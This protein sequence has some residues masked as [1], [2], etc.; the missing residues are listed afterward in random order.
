MQNRSRRFVLPYEPDYT[1]HRNDKRARRVTK[2]HRKVR[3]QVLAPAIAPELS[4]LVIPG[5]SRICRLRSAAAEPFVKRHVHHARAVM[6]V[7]S[8]LE[9]DTAQG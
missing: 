2:L 6:R 7:P 1:A 5:S 9:I 3:K 4:E 8:G